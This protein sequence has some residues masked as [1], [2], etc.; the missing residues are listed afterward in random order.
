MRIKVLLVA[1]IVTGLPV[2]GRAQDET[3]AVIAVVDRLFEGMRKA[4][5]TAMRALFAPDARMWGVRQG[6]ITANPVD[7]WLQSIGRQ[8][9]GTVLNE[10]TWAHEVRVDGTVAQAWMQYDFHIGERFSHC[11]IDAF[12]FIKAGTD[13]KIVGVM[14]T[15]RTTGCTPPPKSP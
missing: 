10:R 4:D 5:T 9:A 6:Q 1:A 15:R 8:P 2:K 14:D 11:G 13:W 3:K 7:S 12:S